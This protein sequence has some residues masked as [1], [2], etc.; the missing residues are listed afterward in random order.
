MSEKNK[1]LILP[2][3]REPG[4]LYIPDELRPLSVKNGKV[5]VRYGDIEEFA[6]CDASDKYI[7]GLSDFYS[8]AGLDVGK[9]LELDV[10]GD[11]LLLSDPFDMSVLSNI[12]KGNIIEDR[13][14]EY[15]FLYGRGELS[16][17]KPVIDDN[18]IDLIAM[19]RGVYHPIY[20]QVKSRFNVGKSGE[21][22][23]FFSQNTF[24]IHDDFFIVGVSFNNETIEVDDKILFVPSRI[25]EEY[26]ILLDNGQIQITVPYIEECESIWS[27]Y[28]IK[29][30]QL[31]VKIKDLSKG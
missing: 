31:A 19:R 23:L 25:V 24:K 15:I 8:R 12:T 14:K 26:G 17:F 16:V 22:V 21:M 13:I 28:F 30:S 4:K 11:V 5:L 18:G 3:E 2:Y 1:R 29:K 10:E 20:L 9:I 7:S 27:P 6:D